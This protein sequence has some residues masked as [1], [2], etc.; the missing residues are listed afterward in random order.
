MILNILSVILQAYTAE[1]EYQVMQLEEEN[2]QLL[3]EE[4]I[5]CSLTPYH[6]LSSEE[7]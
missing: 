5:P 6:E 1:L 4:V 2:I 7:C 3:R